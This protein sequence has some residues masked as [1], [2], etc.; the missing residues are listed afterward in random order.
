MIVVEIEFE[1]AHCPDQRIRCSGVHPRS[2]AHRYL[3]AHE[4]FDEATT[5]RANPVEATAQDRHDVTSSIDRHI[6]N[7]IDR[8]ESGLR[9]QSFRCLQLEAKAVR[10]RYKAMVASAEPDAISLESV[11]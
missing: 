11:T 4:M 10:T 6:T 7:G 2:H 5:D 1:H 9:W 3:G 8:S